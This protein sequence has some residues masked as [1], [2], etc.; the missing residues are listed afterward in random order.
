MRT[1]ASWLPA[2]PVPDPELEYELI[3]WAAIFLWLANRLEY[4][5]DRLVAVLGVL[6]A[7]RRAR[8]G[9]AGGGA[10]S[11]GKNRVAG[12]EPGRT[13]LL[14]G[15]Q[16]YQRSIKTHVKPWG[17]GGSCSPCRIATTCSMG[18]PAASCAR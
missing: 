11:H 8:R 5:G 7:P 17:S 9:C 15:V 6:A 2:L 1:I 4:R 18:S 16:A 10:V 12:T 3:G 13:P 14:R